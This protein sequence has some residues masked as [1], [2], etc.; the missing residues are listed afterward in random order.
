MRRVVNATGVIVHTNLGRAPLS[1]AAVDGDVDG[2]RRDGHRARPRTAG[3]ATA[4][5]APRWRPWRP[6]SRTPATYMSSTTGQRPLLWSPVPWRCGATSWSPA[7]RWSRSATGSASRSCSSRS[8]R[9]CARW[10]RRT[11]CGSPTMQRPL[12]HDTAFVLKVHPSN[13]VIS[14]FTSSVTVAELAPLCSP[15]GVPVVVDIGS[16]LLAPH[17]RLPARTQCRAEPAGRRRP[18]H[19]IR[20]Q[21]ARRA[22]VRTAA[23]PRGSR[24]AT[25]PAP[26]RP[27]AARGQ[28]H[29]GRAGGHPDRTAAA[30]R[31][32][33]RDPPRRSCGLAPSGSP[34]GCRTVAVA[35]VDSA[36]A[37]G[38]GGAPGVEL[39]S[40]AV[41]LPGAGRHPAGRRAPGR[42]TRR[43]GRLLLDLIAVP[44]EDDGLI[45]DAVRRAAETREA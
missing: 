8:G 45:A 42:R 3:A 31:A 5:A 39:P 37:V 35:V 21:A 25:A 9:R 41:A 15:A 1:D 2:R 29:D 13:F 44:A 12:D 24:R 28:A 33:A 19:R 10:V 16:G 14:G 27:G 17:P 30:G 22:A 20:R 18:G 7:A 34:P 43:G 26:P 32:G 36:A 38:G 4:A 40:A 23:R 6:R 11:G